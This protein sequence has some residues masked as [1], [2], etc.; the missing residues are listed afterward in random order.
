MLIVGSKTGGYAGI[1]LDLTDP[2]AW[3]YRGASRYIIHV[4]CKVGSQWN[5]AAKAAKPVTERGVSVEA[6]LSG[7]AGRIST[8][9]HFPFQLLLKLLFLIT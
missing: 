2:A 6:P 4:V 1:S 8:T 7:P 9:S 5:Q 3:L